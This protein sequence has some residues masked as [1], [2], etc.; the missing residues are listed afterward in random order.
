MKK[1]ALETIT[2][3]TKNL[4]PMKST[5]TFDRP[6]WMNEA[7]AAILLYVISGLIVEA[8]VSISTPL[9]GVVFSNA[10]IVAIQATANPNASEVDFYDGKI[11]KAA[12]THLINN[13]FAYDWIMTS[14]NNGTNDWTAIAL[15]AAGRSASTS[16]VVSL[17]VQIPDSEPPTIL[18]QPRDRTASIGHS[19][20]LTLTADGA[21]PLAYQWFFDGAALPGGNTA[22]LELTDVSTNLAGNYSVTVSNAFGVVTSS[23]AIL[24]VVKPPKPPSGLRIVP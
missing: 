18:V 9:S 17:I 14:T 12:V 8:Q 1:G 7:S 13:S 22:S 11:E 4:D 15:D 3:V 16:S 10:Q 5:N 2:R 24:K 20:I 21:P 23:P 6:P 19:A